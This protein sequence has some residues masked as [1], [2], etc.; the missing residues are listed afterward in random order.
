MRVLVYRPL[1]SQV[2][3][4]WLR[5]RAEASVKCPTDLASSYAKVFLLVFSLRAASGWIPS[6]FPQ[7]CPH[8]CKQLLT[9]AP[10]IYLFLEP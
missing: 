5:T 1:P 8:A 2:P 7:A 3:A 4:G 10:Q 6:G 9:N